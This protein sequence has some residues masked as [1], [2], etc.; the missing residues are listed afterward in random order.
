MRYNSN[1]MNIINEQLAEYLVNKYGFSEFTYTDTHIEISNY[2][3]PKM[4]ELKEELY[5]KI[6]SFYEIFNIDITIEIEEIEEHIGELL[7]I[8]LNIETY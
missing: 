2:T 1:F 8:C 7:Y 6:K 3:S 5:N 4:E